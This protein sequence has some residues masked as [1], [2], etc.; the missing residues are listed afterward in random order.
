[1]AT[2]AYLVHERTKGPA[3]P[4]NAWII[5]RKVKSQMLPPVAPGEKRRA[6][7]DVSKIISQMWK[8]EPEHVKAE[9][10]RRAEAEKARHRQQFPEYKF[11]PKSK[12]VKERQKAVEAAQKELKRANAKKARARAAAPYVVP[13]M[14]APPSAHTAG[15]PINPSEADSPGAPSPLFSDSPSPASSKSV[16]QALP[17]PGQPIQMYPIHTPAHSLPSAES[18][19]SHERPLPAPTIYAASMPPPQAH[20]DDITRPCLPYPHQYQ[21]QNPPQHQ[22]Q[23]A[24][25]SDLINWNLPPRNDRV[26]LRGISSKASVFMHVSSLNTILTHCL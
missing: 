17:L 1:M 5:Y 20:P 24:Y 26:T 10:E 13:V 18:Q 4:S 2:P 22:Q 14:V 12:A 16:R 19:Q 3:R 11:N 8:E 9:Y 23:E 15:V 7:A 21:P 6:Q 25:T